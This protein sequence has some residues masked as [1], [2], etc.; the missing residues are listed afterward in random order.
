VTVD[1]PLVVQAAEVCGGCALQ[2]LCLDQNQKWANGAKT[3]V[4]L[5]PPIV[6][7][8]ELLL[9]IEGVRKID[10]LEQV[11]PEVME[12]VKEFVFGW[13]GIDDETIYG[14]KENVGQVSRYVNGLEYGLLTKQQV[15]KLEIICEE[16]GIAKPQTRKTVSEP[17]D[18]GYNGGR[19]DREPI[20]EPHPVDDGN[21]GK[22]LV[23][24][25]RADFYMDAACRGI[26]SNLFFP[27][28]DDAE[29]AKQV[30][31]ECSVRW[32]CLEFALDTKQKVGVWGGATERE[33][34]R[35]LRRR[36][37]SA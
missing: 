33:R 2:E 17:E 12:I 35:I 4:P 5:V 34:R 1:N 32:D 7:G 30:C 16:L 25:K 14:L 20:S 36:R 37:R 24:R 8:G 28:S 23:A 26:D 18:S 11:S 29:I 10:I 21:K 15:L 3:D 9:E 31:E 22:V 19:S 6:S 13:S 27:D